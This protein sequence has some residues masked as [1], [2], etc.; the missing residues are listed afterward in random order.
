[1]P[2]WRKLTPVYE[3]RLSSAALMAHGQL[4]SIG[5]AHLSAK[6]YIAPHWHETYELGFVCSGEGIIVL[7]EQEFPF[8]PGQVYIINHLQ[9]HMGYT[10]NDYARLFVVHFLPSIL[11]EGWVGQ[12]CK[13]AHTPF[14]HDFGYSPLVPLHDPVTLPA[15]ALLEAIQDEWERRDAAWQIIIG[16]LLLQVVGQ[17]TRRALARPDR[18]PTNYQQRE[19]LQRIEPILRLIE[20]RYAEPISLD[21]MAQIAYVSRS[22][23]CALFQTALK[24]TPITYRNARRLAEARQLLKNTNQTIQEIA[25]RVGFSSVQEFNRL[26]RRESG[27]TPSE[28]RQRFAETMLISSNTPA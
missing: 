18:Q 14:S 22:H 9:P 4:F 6:D 16:G 17:L 28:F 7:G 27:Y 12:M 26:F 21:E 1:M 19:A 15:R 24:T 10:D 20:T 11:D 5:D 3:P 25:H 8:V 23:C 13:E 2:D